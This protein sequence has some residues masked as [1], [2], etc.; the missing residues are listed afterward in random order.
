[1]R[2]YEVATGR[3]VFN[4]NA[5]ITFKLGDDEMTAKCPT[6]GQ[7]SLFFHGGRS[8]GMRSIEALIEFFSDVLGDADWRKVEAKLRDGMDIDVL[9]EISNDLIGE[10]SGRPIR[11]S[12]VSSPTP[13]G[14]GRKSTVKRSATVPATTSN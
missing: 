7:L 13:N 2:E 8:G 4:N 14:T 11:P 10:W 3:A 5:D 1:M 12:S 6:T 9:S